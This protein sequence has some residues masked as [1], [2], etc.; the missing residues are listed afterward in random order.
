MQQA[1]QGAG[2]GLGSGAEPVGGLA[3]V[4]TALLRSEK[5]KYAYVVLAPMAFVF[6]TTA[7][8][9][10]SFLTTQFNTLGAQLD[11]TGWTLSNALLAN[12]LMQ[13]ALNILILTSMLAILLC[14]AWRILRPP[15][16]SPRPLAPASAGGGP[17][18]Q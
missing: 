15:Q 11:K 6:T 3:V 16:S 18:R 17:R 14:A 1:V 7:S 13:A 9:S 4:A 2:D 12:T 10:V 5:K 8:A